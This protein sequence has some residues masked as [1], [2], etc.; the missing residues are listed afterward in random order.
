METLQNRTTT[1]NKTQLYTHTIREYCTFFCDSDE[2]PVLPSRT[3]VQL[4]TLISPKCRRAGG[5]P[6]GTAILLPHLCCKAA[7]GPHNRP[8]ESPHL[9]RP[10]V[11]VMTSPNDCSKELLR[12][13]QG[14]WRQ[15]VQLLLSSEISPKSANCLFLTQR[16]W[17]LLLCVS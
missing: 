16:D 14:G 1:G 10:W 15:T 8:A 7:P 12:N 2:A 5:G 13:S 11:P 3:E 17:S 4:R 6:Q 9:W